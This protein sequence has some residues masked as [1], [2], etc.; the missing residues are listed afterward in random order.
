MRRKYPRAKSG[1]VFTKLSVVDIYED[2]TMALCLCE[3]G[4]YLR[5]RERSLG[6]GNTRSC[7]CIKTQTSRARGDRN[8]DYSIQPEDPALRYIPLTKG[9]FATIDAHN[10][11]WLK[12][13]SWCALINEKTGGIY[14]IRT[15]MVA[16]KKVKVLMHRFILGMEHED[17]REGDHENMRTLDNRVENLRI[18]TTPQNRQNSLQQAQRKRGT[19]KGASFLRG[20]WIAQIKV[21]GKKMYLGTYDTEEDAHA[22]YRAA[23]EKYHGAFARIK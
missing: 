10:Y 5:V 19:L 21:L 1:D 8:K 12:R 6:S 20:K 15:E 7:G 23:A 13:W 4:N 22:A 9:Y 18:A 3:C 16:G 2:G 17:E 14:A 11:E